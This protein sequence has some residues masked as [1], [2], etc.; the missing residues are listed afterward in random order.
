MSD[1]EKLKQNWQMSAKKKRYRRKK[2]NA[3][4]NPNHIRPPLLTNPNP[5]ATLEGLKTIANL[6]QKINQQS[7]NQI[8]PGQDPKPLVSGPRLSRPNRF[9]TPNLTWTRSQVSTEPTATQNKPSEDIDGQKI[10][11]ENSQKQVEN[12]QSKDQLPEESTAKDG[13]NIPKPSIQKEA[14]N[15]TTQKSLSKKDVMKQNIHMR[16]TNSQFDDFEIYSSPSFIN[17]DDSDEVVELNDDNLFNIQPNSDKTSGSKKNLINPNTQMNF[18]KKL[19]QQYAKKMESKI[20]ENASTNEPKIEPEITKK[21]NQE[22]IEGVSA[23]IKTVVKDNISNAYKWT[24]PRRTGQLDEVIERERIPRGI[25]R[26]FLLQ[27]NNVGAIKPQSNSQGNASSSHELTNQP[28][29]VSPEPKLQTSVQTNVET[30]QPQAYSPT[31]IYEEIQDNEEVRE[32]TESPDA[33]EPGQKRVSAFQRLG[34]LAQTKKPK[35]TINLSL[36]KDESVREVVD[37]TNINIP[38]HEREYIINSTNEIVVKYL[39]YWPWKK[40]LSIRKRVTARS[41]KTVMMMEKE[42]ME[43][44]YEKDNL[45]IMISVTGY[46]TSWTKEDVLDVI[47][48]YLKGK[49]FIPCFIEFTTK[50]CKFFVLRSRSALLAIHWCG[51]CIRKDDIELY[52]TIS[53]TAFTVKHVDFIPRL[54]LRKLLSLR[55]DEGKLDLSEFTLKKDISHFIYYPLHSVFN[56]AELL[57]IQSNIAWDQITELDLSN[58]KITSLEN[59]NLN[60]TVP[61]LRVLNLSNNCLDSVLLLMSNRYLPVQKLYLQGNPLCLDYIDSDHYMK[62]VKKMF[63]TLKELDGVPIPLKGEFPSFKRNYC[64]E[65]AHGITSKFLEVFFP[66]LECEADDREVKEMYHKNAVMTI[67]GKNNFRYNTNKYTRNLLIKSQTILEGNFDRVEGAANIEKLV[68]KWPNFLHDPTT[69]TVDVMFHNDTSTFIKI[70]GILKIT[71]DTLADDE[72]LV[73]FS[74]TIHLKTKNGCEYKIYNEM[75]YWDEPSKEY[76]NSAFKILALDG[77]K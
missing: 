71:T 29:L 50:E 77:I 4:L 72:P 38:V 9:P 36:N 7:L 46:P 15:T 5:A 56:Q 17:F 49:S 53:Y 61:K 25:P 73:A 60:E 6:I 43:E 31:D 69:F 68:R 18:Q 30:V 12:S 35:L 33:L 14:F 27:Q 8:R 21:S 1:S 65:D 16:Q 42:Q 52:L 66:L 37:E 51:F 10:E 74:R 26:S 63:S 55:Y 58:N 22:L 32:G 23:D 62:V 59:F 64:L 67:T 2:K 48:E 11:T 24:K 34:P 3:N 20:Q 39:P 54:V 44:I 13:S 47:M 76:A 70:T 40:H 75:I 19:Q 28:N 41:S 45:F 57:E